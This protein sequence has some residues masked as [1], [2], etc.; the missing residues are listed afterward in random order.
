M[1]FKMS[2][3]DW[4]GDGHKE[5]KEFIVNTNAVTIE[6]VK[7][8]YTKA[9]H[10]TGVDLLESVC[11][12]YEDGEIKKED[13]EKLKAHNL[14]VSDYAE[15]PYNEEEKEKGNLS[16]RYHADSWA[17]FVL[18]FIKLGNPR[19]YYVIVDDEFP[20]FSAGGYGILGD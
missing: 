17:K 19:L 9:V 12:D 14:N 4:G 10:L 5:F 13:I 16:F 18:A 11:S 7:K 15:E 1:K 6:G 2:V 3:G 8:A 20:H